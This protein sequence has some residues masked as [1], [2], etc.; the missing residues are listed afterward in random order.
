MK[1]IILA[2]LTS[3]IISGCTFK[4]PL[5]NLNSIYDTYTISKDE[6]GIYTIIKDNIIQ[7]KIQAKILA[8]PNLSN[9]H[10]DVVSQWAEVLLIGE[11]ASMSDKMELINLAK[12]TMGV[13]HIKTYINLKTENS[14]HFTDELAIL[15]KI[16][17]NLISD[18]LID[19]TNINI[20]IIQCDVVFSGAIATIEQE[21]RALWYA[22]HTDGVNSAY[23]FL[24]ILK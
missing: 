23:S 18:P 24:H 12:N 8:T 4:S 5:L 2:I 11:V 6:R 22:L 3:I 21:K 19:S 13:N 7:K 14:C 9:F 20:H 10:I 16:K 17:T 15:T 1:F